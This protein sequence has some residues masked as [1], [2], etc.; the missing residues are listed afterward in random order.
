MNP[1]NTL[2]DRYCK[3]RCTHKSNPYLTLPNMVY[4]FNP[5]DNTFRTKKGRNKTHK[6]AKWEYLK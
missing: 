4:W 2:P 1:V 5:L 6:I 3:V